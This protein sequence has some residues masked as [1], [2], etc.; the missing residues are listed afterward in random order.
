[1]NKNKIAI[2]DLTPSVPLY[3]YHLM[4]ALG[5][6]NIDVDIFMSNKK[7][8]FNDNSIKNKTFLLNNFIKNSNS[9]FILKRLFTGIIYYINLFLTVR[10]IIKQDYNVV[11]FQWFPSL[12]ENLWEI[13]FLKTLKKNGLKIVYTKHNVFPHDLEDKYKIEYKNRVNKI[14]SYIDLFIVHTNSTKV[15]VIKNYTISSIKI[16]VVPHGIIRPKVIEEKNEFNFK[17]ND[18]VFMHFGLLSNYKGSDIVVSAFNELCNKYSNLK[19][20]LIG[21]LDENFRKKLCD[22]IGE[23][24]KINFI[25]QYVSDELLNYYLNISNFI[26][27]PYREI[28]QSGALLHA[29]SYNKCIIASSLPSFVETLHSFKKN[30]F[31]NIDD[32]ESVKNV[33]ECIMTDQEEQELMI[34]KVKNLRNEYSWSEIAL[35]T[36]QVYK[37]ALKK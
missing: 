22:L 1:M 33:I 5:E 32:I 7:K 9:Q 8:W 3:D 23:N 12:R 35:K 36:N 20:N 16:H 10:Y 25:P 15:Q 37:I 31:V 26:L 2:I 11:H 4:N 28:S 21:P 19:L 30:W 6:K 18:I 27:F 17:K 24:N 34:N 13:F 29:L 14:S